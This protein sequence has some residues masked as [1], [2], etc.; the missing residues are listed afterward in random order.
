[1]SFKDRNAIEVA[2]I[3]D[4]RTA[5]DGTTRPAAHCVWAFNNKSEAVKAAAALRATRVSLRCEVKISKRTYSV[6]RAQ[7]EMWIVTERVRGSACV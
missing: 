3:L 1:M 7:F 5:M 6:E 4:M 2:G